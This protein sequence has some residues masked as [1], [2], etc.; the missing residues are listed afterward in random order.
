MT[1]DF[2]ET[3]QNQMET[4]PRGSIVVAND[5]YP[6]P[7]QGSGSDADSPIRVMVKKRKKANPT[8]SQRKSRTSKVTSQDDK[9]ETH[10]AVDP[11]QL[12]HRFTHAQDFS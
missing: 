1:F 2:K 3:Q 8:S 12:S 6:T 4:H 10:D 5:A 9:H 7:D 11:M